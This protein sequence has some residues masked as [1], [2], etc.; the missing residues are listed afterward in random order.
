MF[1][2]V[3]GN[4][5]II[6]TFLLIIGFILNL[7]LAFIIIF[8]ERN[9][10]SAT[11]TWAWLFVL[12]VLPLIGFVLYLFFGRTVSKRKME[13]HNGK[14]LNAFKQLI[15]DQIKSFD[16]HNYGTSNELVTTHHDLVR[17][18]LMNQD[19]FLTEN[20]QVDVFTD[21]HELFDQVIE[22]IYNA[23][24]YIHLEYYTFELDGLGKR[25]LDALETKLKEGLE[26]KLL[27]DDVGSKKVG[28][29]KFKQFK[30]LG[31]EVEAF[32]ASK[33]PLINFRMNNRNHRKIIVIDGQK[34][35]IGVVVL[36]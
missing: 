14:E 18:L 30:A 16:K 11:S 3:T 26:V 20:N 13:K 36:I 2:G 19:G 8:L 9:R 24:H 5:G 35:Y 28:L 33:F 27:Y 25:I 1:L 31:G 4:L 22:D 34:G 23:K 15:D 29:S 6:F 7:I 21:G 10:R 12:L 32:F 17:M